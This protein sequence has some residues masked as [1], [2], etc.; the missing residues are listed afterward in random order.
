[1]C[2]NHAGQVMNKTN[3]TILLAIIFFGLLFRVIG[4]DWGFPFLLHPDEPAIAEKAFKMIKEETMDPQFYGRPN[5]ISIY[6][7]ALLYK[8]AGVLNYRES[9]VNAF[10]TNK[11]FYYLLSRIM[12][13]I[14]GTFSIFIAYL[15]GREF[16]R[17]LALISAL[18][19]AFFSP[20]VKHSHFITPDI[21]LTSLILVVILFS[22]K[23]L[24]NPSNISLVFMC[25]FSALAVGEK[26]PGALTM[27]LIAAVIIT[28]NFKNRK[29]IFKKL[30]MS[31]VLFLLFLFVFTPYLF[32]N[33]DRVISSL[34]LAARPHHA[35]ADGLGFWG[36]LF[37]YV[38]EYL[39]VTGFILLSFS[40]IG[41]V[42]VIKQHRV[43]SIP[44][45]FGFIYWISLSVLSLHWERWA[46]PMYITPLLLASYGINI[47]IY[48][49]AKHGRLIRFAVYS[50]LFL[51]IFHLIMLSSVRTT[52]LTLDDTRYISYR[53][54]MANGIKEEDSIY[55]N[56]APFAPRGRFWFNFLS[57][58][59]D[60]DYMRD[61]KYVIVSSNQYQR[62]FNERTRYSKIVSKYEKIFS[63]PLVKEFIPTASSYK[64][65]H[66]GEIR[67]I[68]EGFRFFQSYLMN[69]GEMTI[70]PTIRIFRASQFY[71]NQAVKNQQY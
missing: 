57:H 43:H 17:K 65:N 11:N 13:A 44:I 14:W 53:Y 70:G 51:S 38:R 60:Q 42:Y 32:I 15:I 40:V 28:A 34:V 67:N 41:C 50:A 25:L 26:Y 7:N 2:Y 37:F 46:L 39:S 12:V 23:Y 62:F 63:L 33:Y 5:H 31:I 9:P 22:I 36:N 24:K 1:M 61:K 8:V 59:D 16:D 48:E 30:S 6:A 47:F 45:F 18:L 66:L 56:Y 35:G 10:S 68:I 52:I 21:P 64:K 4:A 27:P 3:K 19:F 69:R 54:S 71:K 55:Q 29:L 49:S 20:Y 58:Y